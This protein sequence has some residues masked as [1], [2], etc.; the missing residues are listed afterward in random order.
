MTLQ[1]RGC[2]SVP[3]QSPSVT[4]ASAPYGAAQRPLHQ[5]ASG[6]PGPFVVSG[7]HPA[8]HSQ[9]PKFEPMTSVRFMPL[10]RDRVSCPWVGTGLPLPQ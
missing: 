5:K 3:L 2:L 9:G 7:R 1:R 10:D 8:D 4:P 6:A